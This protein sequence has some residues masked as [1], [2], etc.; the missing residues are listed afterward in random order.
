MSAQKGKVHGN[1]NFVCC[2]T[3]SDYVLVSHSKQTDLLHR[4]FGVSLLQVQAV[5]FGVPT[6]AAFSMPAAVNPKQFNTMNRAPASLT[7]CGRTVSSECQ[8]GG[9]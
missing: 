3:I 8:Y 7:A 1:P 4:E 9:V 5:A 2:N 6:S